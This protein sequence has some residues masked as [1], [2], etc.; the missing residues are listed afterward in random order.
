M[1]PGRR[2]QTTGNFEGKR[3]KTP[4][5]EYEPSRYTFKNI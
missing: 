2:I 5:K 4:K 1:I 3:K